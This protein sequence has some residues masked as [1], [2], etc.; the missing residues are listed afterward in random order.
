MLRMSTPLPEDLEKLTHG[1]IGC[2]LAV[3]RE[4]GPGLIEG[5]YSKAI[6][7]ELK[8]ADI[9][10]ERQKRVSVSYRGEFLCDQWL[11]F[12]IDGRLV[13]EIKSVEQ[14]AP[15]HHA[16]LLNYMRLAG[17]RV[18]LLM[19]F[20]VLVLKDGIKRKVL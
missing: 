9:P 5:I 16:Q 20:N 1:T 11:D 18:G 12:I 2:C 14:L 19:N 17:V 3:H 4:L 10:Y 8:V 6:C 7:R 15:V 13:L